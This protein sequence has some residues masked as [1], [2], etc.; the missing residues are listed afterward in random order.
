MELKL[1]K[2]SHEYYETLRFAPFFCE[3]M[4]EN[5]V[6][7]SCGDIARIVDTTGTVCLT[8]RELTG[9]GRFCASGS[10]EASV[11]YIPEKE[12]G[13]RSLHFQIPFQC[14]GEGQG[15]ASCEDLDIRGELHSID[16]RVLNPRKVLTRANLT[17]YPA[18][19]RHVSLSVCTGTEEESGEGIQLLREQK[20][21][22]VTA[23]VREKE[24]T[25]TEELPLSP[26]RGGAEEILSTRVDVRGTDSKLIGSK[27]V[28]KGFIAVSVLY[29]ENGGRLSL[30]QQ[31]LPFSQ[32]LEG[33]GFEEECESEAAY[34]LLSAECR[35]G[36]EGAP[37]DAYTLTLSVSLRT[38]VTVWRTVELSFISDLYSTAAPVTCQTE[39]LSLVEDSQQ[40]I[41]RQ[42]V[43]ELLETGA[44]VRSVLDTEVT[45]GAA[46]L[47]GGEWK[48]PVWARCL[49]LDENNML[50]SVHREFSVSLPAEQEGE[51]LECAAGAASH[52]DITANIMPEGVEL[53]FPIECAISTAVRRRYLCVSGGETEE[54]PQESGPAPSLI[55][56]KLGQGE[57]LWSV[58]KQYRATREGIL[59][60]ND[61]TEESQITP[62]KLLLIPRARG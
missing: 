47:S 21:T 46:A 14:Y 33:N 27:L 24:F 59:S 40:N 42:N 62:D 52:G 10:V 55:L 60:V 32:I 51:G 23:G 50:G 61:L 34:R 4:R 8:G 49:Y 57:T 31:E 19:C 35:P 30:L 29:R 58:A 39:E 6:P 54:E 18:G 56:R 37:D 12:E 5:I 2:A 28:V 1:Q 17:L 11:L 9:D 43:R 25:F 26:G 7:D 20:Q 36:T 48:L 38:R 13:V 53:R 44:A 45:C 15:D 41:R 22:R 16:T 3:T